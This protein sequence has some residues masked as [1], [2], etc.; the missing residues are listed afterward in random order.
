MPFKALKVTLISQY[1]LNAA[2]E[3]FIV[4]SKS[5]VLSRLIWTLVTFLSRCMI[6]TRRIQKEM[7]RRQMTDTLRGLGPH[8]E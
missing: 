4:S 6:R 5:S 2:A 3:S 8:T 1:H 7:T